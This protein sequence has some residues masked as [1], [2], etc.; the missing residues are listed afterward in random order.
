MRKFLLGTIALV[1]VGTGALAADLKPVYKAPPAT[2][3]TESGWYVWVDGDYQR[4]RLPAYALG[5]K[6]I[7]LIP[8][9]DL[10][11]V[12]SFDASLNGAGVR[13]AIGYRLPG[14]NV[15]LELGASYVKADGSS[16]QGGA[17]GP[18]VGV[19]L[20]SGAFNNTGF[21][22]NGA[23][24]CSASGALNT[25]Y[26]SWQVNGK[27]AYDANFGIVTVTPSAA[28]FGGTSHANQ[29]LTQS[30][31]QFLLGGLSATGLYAADTA[32]R[33]TD[34]GGRVG[35]NASVPLA[36]W[37]SVGVGGW[38]GVAGRT[39]SLSGSDAASSTFA[40]FNGAST[41]STSAETTVF[42]ANAEA[43]VVITPMSWL[44]LRGFVGLNYDDKVPG[45]SAPR[46]A[47]GV[48]APTAVTPAGIVFGRET[49]YYAGGGVLVRFGPGPAIVNY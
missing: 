22:C 47:G 37:L 30:F 1:T 20:L 39:A 34:F 4:V 25:S 16:S 44:S 12:Q 32:L 24:T 41:I 13:S 23:F 3:I 35:L 10:G 15:R 27:A 28:L 42:L 11:P 40:F 33:W 14:S 38:I 9:P 31:S 19:Q 8:F 21:Q 49:S 29:T 45:I 48:L 6:T 5:L 36:S 17:A 2:V 7:G 26:N 43:G 46:F 18:N